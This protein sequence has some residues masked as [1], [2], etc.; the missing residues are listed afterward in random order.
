MRLLYLQIYWG[1]KN[2]LDLWLKVQE[3][4]GKQ[5]TQSKQKSV[6]L[7]SA[8]LPKLRR[9]KLGGLI[10]GVDDPCCLILIPRLTIED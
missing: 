9:E 4:V 10:L 7:A 5:H 2:T 3:E 8:C 1:Q 6:L